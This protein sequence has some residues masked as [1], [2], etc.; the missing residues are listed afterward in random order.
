MDR[1]VLTPDERDEIT[2]L[3]EEVLGRDSTPDVLGIAEE[4]TVLA[5]RLPH[6]LRDFLAGIR[7]DESEIAVISGLSVGDL[8][9]TP[10]DW[11]AAAATGAGRHAEIVLLLC[12]SALA[13]PFG[14]ASQQDGRIVHDVCPGR[15]QESSF[16]SASSRLA[17]S[18]HTEDVFHPCRGDYVALLC[19]RNPEQTATT[20]ARLDAREVPEDFLAVLS[21]DRFR[22]Y[23]DDSHVPAERRQAGDDRLTSRYHTVGKVAFGPPDRPYLRF[24]LDFMDAVEGD[25]DAA[26][27]ISVM[28]DYLVASAQEVVL[29]PGDLVM[30]DNYRVVHGRNPFAPRWDGNDR[31]LKRLNLIRDIRRIYLHNGSRSRILG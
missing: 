18:L 12:A 7:A 19:T 14:W 3:V 27:A 2:A 30:I 6:R 15:G 10:V 5:E 20:L 17:L 25:E 1:L 24:D 16:T 31:W 23:P 9:P 13:E 22:F 4:G 28:H 29:A 11:R 21:E 26:K 8:P